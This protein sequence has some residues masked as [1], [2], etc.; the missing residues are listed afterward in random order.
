MVVLEPVCVFLV[1]AVAVIFVARTH[2]PFWDS[3]LRVTIVFGFLSGCL[4]II[5]IGIENGSPLAVRGP[6]LPITF[7]LIIFTLWGIAGFRTAR[8]LES[9]RG[10]LLAAVLSAAICMLIA[11]TFGF[12]VEFFLAPP[13][14]TYVSTWAEFKRSGWTD[15]GAFAVANT[16]D[17]GFTHLVIAP[18]VALFF[19][20]LGS[21]IGQSLSKTARISR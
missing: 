11:V 16:L 4:E 1:Y 10:G 20:G 13:E 14:S 18:I 7:M 3:V 21:L 8:T 17:S 6:I 9:T 15:A 5:N 19:G 2:G 12:V